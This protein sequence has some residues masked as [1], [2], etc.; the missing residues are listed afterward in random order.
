MRQNMVA[1]EALTLP[2]GSYK[3]KYLARQFRNKV[4]T[5]PGFD[6]MVLIEK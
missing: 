4:R 2:M 3:T 1:Q 6:D 5:W